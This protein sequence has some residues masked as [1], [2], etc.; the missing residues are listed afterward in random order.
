MNASGK[1]PL[2]KILLEQKVISKAKLEDLLRRQKDSGERLGSLLDREEPDKHGSLLKA[3]SIQHGVPAINLDELVIHLPVLRLVPKD[4]ANKHHVL[5]VLEKDD[6]LFMVMSDPQNHHVVDEIEFVTGKKVF[7][8]VTLER[9]L[10]QAVEE[11]YRLHEEGKLFFRGKDVND[12]KFA[13]V[14]ASLVEKEET[15]D[16]QRKPPPPPKA[17]AQEPEEISE[18][19]H[20]PAEDLFKSDAVTTSV[21]PT[22]PQ[23]MGPEE[24]ID[25]EFQSDDISIPI[26]LDD[27]KK[28]T[29][30]LVVDDEEDILN[31]ISKVLVENSYRVLT[32]ASGREALS[33]VKSEQLDLIILDAMLPEIHGFDICRRIKGS[34]KYGHIPVIMISAIYRGWR[35]A[36]DL[37]ESYGVD[38]FIEKPFKIQNLLRSVQSMLKAKV[39][40]RP[41]S[42]EEMSREAQKHLEDSARA[43]RAGDLG[44]AIEHLKAAI[45][46]DPLSQKLHYNL[47]LVYGKAGMVYY[48]ISELETVLEFEPTMFQA[49]KNL[50]ILYQEAG[51]KNK[52]IEMWERALSICEDDESKQ[53]MREHLMSLL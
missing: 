18:P 25:I 53:K 22:P 12:Q 37:K 28:A 41:E 43:Y 34:T 20:H 35:F 40:A 9:S 47:A 32:A 2:G 51:F 17:P 44:A 33:I 45:R 15:T 5:P 49:M 7:R 27:S 23:T 26:E 19:I 36:R 4:V 50:A 1:K 42:K 3:L 11:C 52:A 46:I 29:T 31:L 38:E 10:Q 24:D 21:P 13:K 6:H 39:P 8:Y 48:A 14:K 30:I 16:R